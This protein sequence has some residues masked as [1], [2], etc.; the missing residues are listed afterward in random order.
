[1]SYD[2]YPHYLCWFDPKDTFYVPK[3]PGFNHFVGKLGSNIDLTGLESNYLIL[4]F[5]NECLKYP[6]KK[7]QCSN[8]VDDHVHIKNVELFID[9]F[10]CTF[11]REVFDHLYKTTSD[12]MY[13]RIRDCM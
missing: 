7:L 13:L 1:M 11:S 8:N 5:Q 3:L 9:G 10:K 12:P 2:C 4:P 6:D